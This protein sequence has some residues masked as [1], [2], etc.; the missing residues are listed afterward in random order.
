MT[1][2]EKIKEARR[3]MNEVTQEDRAREKTLADHMLCN[4]GH[5]HRDHGTSHSINYTRGFCSQCDCENFIM[6]LPK[7]VK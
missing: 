2:D 7:H 4:C 5:K 1:R 6:P 3:L